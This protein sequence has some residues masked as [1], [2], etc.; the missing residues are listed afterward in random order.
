MGH[1]IS[2]SGIRPDPVKVAAVRNMPEP[3]SQAE[4][5]RFLGMCNYLARFMPHLS[6]VSE[7]LRRLT[8][9]GAEFSW[10]GVQGRAF[11]DLKTLIIEEQLLTFYDVKKQVVIQCDA[12]TSGLG[13]TQLQ[14]GRP[15]IS[16][17]RAL[18][19]SEQNYAALELECLAVVF[20]CQK[21]DQYIYGKQVRVETDHK[22]LEIIT[23]KS[24]LAAP[25]RLQRMLLQ[26][27]RYELDVHYIPGSQQWIA[28]TLSRAP[29]EAPPEVNTSSRDV[30]FQ[31]EIKDTLLPEVEVIVER[32]FIPISDI[33]LAAVKEMAQKDEEQIML[34]RVICEGWP[35]TRQVAPAVVHPYWNFRDVL[36]T[37]DGVVY[38]S[39]QVVVPRML[40]K[41]FL[42][43]LHASHQGLDATM[44]R[45]RDVVYWP[46]MQED[47]RQV[48][49]QCR[50]CEENQ[51]A[52]PKQS[53]L[54][55]SV[56][57]CPWAKVGIDLFQCK[58]Q[59]YLLM[60]D[61]L[62][63]YFEISLL[64]QT[65]AA[66]VIRAVKEQFARHGVPFLLQSDGGS[67]FVSREFQDF[68]STWGFMHT[69]SSP[70]NSQSNGKAESAVKIAKRLL[71]LSKD[72]WLALLEWRNTPTV[73]IG[74]SP[75]QWLFSRRTRGGVVTSVE[76]LQ[77]QV[78]EDMWQRKLKKQQQIQARRGVNR[79]P[80]PPLTIGQPVLV[81]DWL[82]KKTQWI[83]GLCVG[84]LS[85][86]SYLV[87]VDG[88][89]LRRNRVFLR[90]TTQAPPPMTP[91][92]TETEMGTAKLEEGFPPPCSVSSEPLPHPGPGV[93]E[94]QN[95]NLIME[96]TNGRLR[97]DPGPSTPSR[98][99]IRN[100]NTEP[101]PAAVPSSQIRTSRYGRILKEPSRYTDFVKQ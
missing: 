17:S 53:L 26:L 12:S 36:T 78:Q 41:E 85:D 10:T 33:R 7:P 91:P 18:T 8:D 58:G 50:Q 44:R 48:T 101:V 83:R 19:R 42:Q 46:G 5:R 73:D 100:L 4:V 77:P 32:D 86:R 52:Q 29:V 39:G 63:D 20:A 9:E 15:V 66:E 94:P 70:Y 71:K 82:S 54:T 65:S 55:H 90:P 95:D 79:N 72:P 74:S 64:K 38:K 76:K 14:E 30:V 2:A 23:K 84:Q 31:L 56:P 35:S 37:Q 51:P 62:T 68:A 40:R 13:A 43:C 88:Q 47:I 21:F 81:Q 3:K 49:S 99:S 61:Y 1:L 89:L 87:E 11:Q 34:R 69:F 97:Q 96:E 59:D 45:A 16:A 6:S 28:D 92:V 80:L 67:Q 60:V 93:G 24:L 98:V 57:A 22:P 25:R 27:Q 75:C